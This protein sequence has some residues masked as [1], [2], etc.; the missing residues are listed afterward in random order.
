MT[1]NVQFDTVANSISAL[2]I[3]GV[4]IHD[5]DD[6][7]ES[8]EMQTPMLIPQPNGFVSDIGPQFQSYGSGG[9]A[10]IDL[11]YTL[12]YVYLHAPIGSGISTYDI[13]KGLLTNVIA[14]FEAIFANDAPDGAIDLQLS[15]LS[16]IGTVTDPAGAEYWGILFSLRVLEH[17]Q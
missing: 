9:T 10:K 15:T 17:V 1:I 11:Q 13:Y 3:D 7:P 2:S 14:I 12:N 5:I 6:I 8:A 4:N 16:D